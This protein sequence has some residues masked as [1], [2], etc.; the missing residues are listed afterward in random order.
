MSQILSNES[1]L[2]KRVM[3][4]CDQ[5]SRKC[6][7]VFDI[8]PWTQYATFDIAMEMIFS[9]PVGFVKAG[10]DVD[11]II[12]SLHGLFTFVSIAGFH[13][14]IV[15]LLFHP[16]LFPF[17]GPKPTDKVGPGAFQG[18]AA[19][20]VG[21]RLEPSDSA[22]RRPDILQWILDHPDKEGQP[23]PRVMLEQEAIGITL[24]ASDTTAGTLRAILLGVG[25]NP[26]ILNKLRAQIDNADAKGLLS[27]PPS[28]D[29]IKQHIPYLEAIFKEAQRTHPI[30][31]IPLL[32]KVP[33]AGAYVSLPPILSPV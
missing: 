26:R 31:G 2:D 23:M 9:D 6:N 3:E 15:K 13:P 14:W 30:P 21:R 32:R 5:L 8:A 4:F 22:S 7:E 25:S 27:T 12:A 24:A 20:Q 29:Q 16:W 18:F 10:R 33:K 28:Y 17:I 11:G 1:S 19:R